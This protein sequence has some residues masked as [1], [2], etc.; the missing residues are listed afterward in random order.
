M[1]SSTTVKH[2]YDTMFSFNSVNKPRFII[3]E[4]DM[5]EIAK[6]YYNPV[7]HNFAN[8][9]IPGGPLS[10]FR[11]DG[12][13]INILC[14]G[15]T[16]EDQLIQKYK[17][18]IILPR[19]MYPIISNNKTALLYS[20]CDGLPSVITLPSIINPNLKKKNIYISMLE[21][22]ELMLYA[23]CLNNNTLIT[24]L[25]GCGVYGMK[26]EELADLWKTALKISDYKPIDIVFV[27]K[28]DEYTKYYSKLFDLFTI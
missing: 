8:N 5:F 13:F 26:P 3:R 2:Y 24:G 20:I 15:R 25:W 28:Q 17:D 19:D 21:R 7:I 6:E 9:E 16:Q 10:V 12:K 23:A 1:G 18:K 27:I 22:I 11:P 4:G 14:K